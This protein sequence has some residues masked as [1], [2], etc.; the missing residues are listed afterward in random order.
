MM[1]FPSDKT[2]VLNSNHPL[3]KKV[4]ESPLLTESVKLL[5]EHIYDMALMA[6]KPLSGDKMQN[7]LKRQATLLLAVQDNADAV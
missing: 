1:E 7:F 6:H 2:L 4:V 5:C 3:I